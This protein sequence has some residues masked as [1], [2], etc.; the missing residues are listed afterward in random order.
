MNVKRIELSV[1]RPARLMGTCSIMSV[2]IFDESDNMQDEGNIWVNG[3]HYCS[4]QDII[5]ELANTY[6][7]HPSVI[8]IV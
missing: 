8:E 4:D 1:E 2:M 6:K 7:V 5:D 3:K